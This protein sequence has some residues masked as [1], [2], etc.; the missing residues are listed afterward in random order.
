ML[1]RLAR[2]IS[3]AVFSGHLV[4]ATLFCRDGIAIH[5]AQFAGRIISVGYNCFKQETA[6]CLPARDSFLFRKREQAET[7]A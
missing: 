1:Q 2:A 5:R 4:G 6:Q 3:G 7:N